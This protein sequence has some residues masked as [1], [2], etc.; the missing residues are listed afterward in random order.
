MASGKDALD[1]YDGED[2]LLDYGDDLEADLL[3]GDLADV[4]AYGDLEDELGLDFPLEADSSSKKPADQNGSSSSSS[5]AVAAVKEPAATTTTSALDSAGL[6]DIEYD[7]ADYAAVDA[8]SLSLRN[9]NDRS[10]SKDDGR[11]DASAATSTTSQK[12]H[13]TEGQS[14][15]ELGGI[16]R[17]SASFTDDRSSYN[18]N[19]STRGS[20]GRGGAMRGRGNM[21]YGGRGTYQGGAGA[22]RG[23]QMMGMGMNPQ[24]QMYAAMQ[25]QMAMGMGVNGGR[26]PSDGYGNQG[27]GYP[28]YNGG[29]GMGGMGGA[30]GRNIHINPKFQNR[31][32]GP[33]IPGS[34]SG[35]DR[36]LGQQQKPQQ[37]QQSPRQ[38]YQDSDNGQ[39]FGRGSGDQSTRSGSQDRFDN[40]R[41]NRN[42]QYNNERSGSRDGR[43]QGSNGSEQGRR[44]DNSYR[45]SGSSEREPGL[46]QGLSTSK[47]FGRRSNDGG[48]GSWS[49]DSPRHS[50]S[51][52]HSPLP[53]YSNRG[54]PAIGGGSPGSITSR[55]TPGIKRPGGA[56]ED[57]QKAQ[58]SSGSSTPRSEQS[59]SSSALNQEYGSDSGSVSFLRDRRD[60]GDDSPQ[61]RQPEPSNSNAVPTGFVKVENIPE[62]V[63]DASVRQL[64]NGISGV[65]RVLTVSKKGDRTVVLGFASVEEAKFFRR[66]INRTTVEGSLV[67]VTLTSA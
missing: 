67:T 3:G 16:N 53:S 15:A 46:G 33:A 35:L 62:S 18:N 12:R 66:Q 58:K 50:Q 57:S 29:A 27:M 17:Q 10:N 31:A 44:T 1:L 59:R 30:P 8:S 55:L 47:D 45:S 38:S 25:Q 4:E 48:S 64:A 41:F 2:D 39:S 37:E 11:Q 36:A 65:G 21:N 56:M 43:D 7:E 5:T 24:Q 42:Q 60:D 22:S 20:G 34:P 23:G 28:S 13:L 61:H 19:A 26:F 51:Q 32:G 52:P 63:S 40:D 9:N 49:G 54:S 6:D 14:E